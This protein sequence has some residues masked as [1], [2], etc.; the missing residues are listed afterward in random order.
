MVH[1]IRVMRMTRMTREI[2]SRYL[3][4]KFRRRE[5]DTPSGLR[6]SNR[7][8]CQSHVAQMRGYREART[9]LTHSVG[10]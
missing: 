6:G 10:K 8:Y 2:I 7:D 5:C 9:W 3:A 4:R 1:V